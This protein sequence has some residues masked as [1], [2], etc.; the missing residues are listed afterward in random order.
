MG[1]N[2]MAGAL[3]APAL[4]LQAADSIPI[5]GSDTMVILNQRWAEAYAKLGP[6]SRRL[7]TVK[8]VGYR[9]KLD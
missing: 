8:K 9:L 2:I 1:T 5:K 6:E 7:A 4:P 3:L